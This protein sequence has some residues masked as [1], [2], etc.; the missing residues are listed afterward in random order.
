MEVIIRWF[1]QV[2]RMENDRGIKRLRMGECDGARPVD[3][4]RK[5]WVDTVK[6]CLKKKGLDIRQIERRV[7][8]YYRSIWRGFVRGNA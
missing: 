2:D 6:Y 4:P 7:H 5:M 8:D 3:R 1:G